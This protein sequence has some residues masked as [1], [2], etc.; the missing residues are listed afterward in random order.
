MPGTVL[1]FRWTVV[2]KTDFL[3]NLYAFYILILLSVSDEVLNILPL[4][5]MLL[6][7]SL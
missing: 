1:Y 4:D 3:Q 6:V 5:T 7:D 2:N